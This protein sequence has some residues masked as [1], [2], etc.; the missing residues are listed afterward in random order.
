[1]GIE[2]RKNMFTNRAYWSKA[3]PVL[4]LGVFLMYFY[5]GLQSDPGNVLTVYSLDIGWKASAI[6]YPFF[7]RA[8]F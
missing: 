6:I 3:L 2:R 4:I 7:P 1:L 5:S 8:S